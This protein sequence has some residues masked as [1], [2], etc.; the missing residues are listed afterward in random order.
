ML[1][2]GGETYARSIHHEERGGLCLNVC[3]KPNVVQ[4]AKISAL[5]HGGNGATRASGI[6]LQILKE[7]GVKEEEVK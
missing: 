6:C 3:L 2:G 4:P 7:D 1:E 5:L